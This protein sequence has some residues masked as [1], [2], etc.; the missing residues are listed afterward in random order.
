LSFFSRKNQ[1]TYKKAHGDF[2]Q[3]LAAGHIEHEY[4]APRFITR[5]SCEKTAPDVVTRVFMLFHRV[6]AADLGLW[7]LRSAQAAKA[8]GAMFWADMVTSTLRERRIAGCSACWSG[9]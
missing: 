8:D 4:V 3:I 9:V 5:E 6:A 7:E 1:R 2:D